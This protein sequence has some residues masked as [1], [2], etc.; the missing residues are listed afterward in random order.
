MNHSEF[1]YSSNERCQEQLT[2]VGNTVGFGVG[3]KVGC[4][5]IKNQCGLNLI[6]NECIMISEEAIHKERD[7]QQ[8][9]SSLEVTEISTSEKLQLEV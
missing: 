9:A 2:A 1:S 8:W 6:H 7:S 3:A 4:Y 5:R